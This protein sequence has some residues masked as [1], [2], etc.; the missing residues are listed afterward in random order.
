M[1]SCPS[2]TQQFKIGIFSGEREREMRDSVGKEERRMMERGEGVKHWF[3]EGKMDFVKGGR[4]R[5]KV[6]VFPGSLV[7][8]SQIALLAPHHLW[9]HSSFG[10]PDNISKFTPSR[11]HLSKTALEGRGRSGVGKC[12]KWTA[13]A[14]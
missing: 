8:P 4:T 12:K 14:D 2:A 6:Q 7:P 1:Q 5:R 3:E 10:R 9:G 13:A 11:R